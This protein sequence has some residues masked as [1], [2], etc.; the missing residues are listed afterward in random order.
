M[1]RSFVFKEKERASTTPLVLF[2]LECLFVV[3]CFAFVCHRVR[4]S[5][6]FS[7]SCF[8]LFVCCQLC[9]SLFLLLQL[10]PP[11]THFSLASVAADRRPILFLGSGALTAVVKVYLVASWFLFCLA[12][13]CLGARIDSFWSCLGF[14]W[15][16]T[17]VLMSTAC[18]SM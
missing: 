9:E 18:P 16:I 17:K 10:S 12:W 3:A 8:C 5:R 4:L 15:S 14:L 1:A 6:L 7:L 2:F 13:H 11:M